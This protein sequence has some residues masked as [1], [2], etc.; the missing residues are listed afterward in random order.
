MLGRRHRPF[1]VWSAV[2]NGSGRGKA[3]GVGAEEGSFQTVLCVR[4]CVS[5]YRW[6]REDV[7]FDG[8]RYTH[9]QYT[10]AT[11]YSGAIKY[12]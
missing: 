1:T 6:P 12:I 7:I 9:P 5:V 10:L 2:L 11:P 4:V 8:Q 3:E